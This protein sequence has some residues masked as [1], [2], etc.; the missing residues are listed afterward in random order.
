MRRAERH[1]HCLSVLLLDVDHFKQFNDTFGHDAGDAVLRCLSQFLQQNVRNSDIACRYGG[2]ELVLILPNASPE[3]TM[4]RAEHLRQ[5]V[6][7]LTVEHPQS[8]G[9]ITVSVGVACF[10]DHGLS[11]E[12]LLQ[13]AD[14]A[15][16]Q[17]KA[18]GRDRVV[19]ATTLQPM[20]HSQSTT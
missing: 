13:A 10:P 18:T 9:I 2:E 5:G 19:M 4:Q 12:A 8:L 7:R 1:Q 3:D 14:S 17:A 6:K 16:Y 20:K 15:L 11:T